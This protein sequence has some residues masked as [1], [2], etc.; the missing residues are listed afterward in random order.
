MSYNYFVMVSNV[1]SIDIPKLDRDKNEYIT[2]I[3][4]E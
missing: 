1:F 4:S 3:Y 2:E